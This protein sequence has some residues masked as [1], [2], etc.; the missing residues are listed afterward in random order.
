MLGASTTGRQH[1][2]NTRVS[3]YD[4]M[5]VELQFQF[6]FPK[7]ESLK[8]EQKEALEFLLLGR[9]EKIDFY[10]RISNLQLSL[11]YKC[12]CASGQ[13]LLFVVCCDRLICRIE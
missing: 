12:R 7:I 13:D 11:L 3:I 5:A 2:F 8:L 10:G 6:Q 9:D 1:V 4:A